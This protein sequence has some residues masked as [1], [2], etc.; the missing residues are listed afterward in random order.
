MTT[1]TGS[2]LVF[3]QDAGGARAIV[4]VVQS[5][6]ES[7]RRPLQVV[8]H[9]FAA[10]VFREAG[11]AATDLRE[12]GMRVPLTPEE[13]L[14][15]LV[16]WSPAAI[17][18]ATANNSYDPSN[19]ELIRAARELRI[20]CFV[21]MDHWKGWSRLHRDERD[22]YYLPDL[23]GVIDEASRAR[24]IREGVPAE[25]MAI[26]GHPYLEALF[27]SRRQWGGDREETRRSV[28][29]GFVCTLFTQPAVTGEGE[30]VSV[31]PL[32]EG[33][34]AEAV[35]E[36]FR[37]C[38]KCLGQRGRTVQFFIRLHPREIANMQDGGVS[39]PGARTD[40]VSPA[41][42]LARSSN[43]VLG[44][45]SMILYEAMFSGR[46]TFS[47]RIGPLAEMPGAFEDSPGLLPEIRTIEEFEE[48][49]ERLLDTL[50]RG[51]G[52]G[53][54]SEAAAYPLPPGATETCGRILKR[55]MESPRRLP[56]PS[57]EAKR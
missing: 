19:G 41:L 45:D 1:R 40:T 27:A 33:A 18:C 17:F 38:E 51:N 54:P 7:S 47:L 57:A 42:Q 26:V 24:G 22:L 46:P 23:L 2:L 21:I 49:L 34:R 43:L 29:E 4:P 3:A 30:R 31:R 53:S 13:A 14:S 48:A 52:G 35:A 16:R 11:I 32:L 12:F 15:V 6:F 25:Q 28:P 36:V 44:L 37:S 9:L 50:R 55:M 20:P 10:D 39:F 5:L 56:S 8:S